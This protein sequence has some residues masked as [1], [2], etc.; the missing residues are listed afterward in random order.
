MV[1]LKTLEVATTMNSVLIPIFNFRSWKERPEKNT[2]QKKETNPDY[3]L[4]IDK[5]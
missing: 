1:A 2:L 3:P 5:S 4:L